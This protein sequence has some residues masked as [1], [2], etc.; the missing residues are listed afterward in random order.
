MIEEEH[1]KKIVAIALAALMMGTAF[2]GCGGGEPASQEAQKPTQTT[3][4]EPSEEKKEEKSTTYGTAEEGK[5]VLGLDDS[6][7]PMGFRDENNEIVGFDIDIAQ[8]VCDNLGLELVLQ[9]INWDTKEME[10]ET[11]NIDVI[12]N[13]LTITPER[14][15]S[16][17]LSKPYLNNNQ[18][19]CV[20]ADSEIS[21]KAE[22]AGKTVAV[23][24][25]SSADDALMKD[26]ISSEIAEKL[27]YDN[28][29]SALLDCK[30]GGCD[31][32]ILDEVVANYYAAKEPESYKVLE[33][34]L[35]KEEYAI[36]FKK[37][38]TKLH[39]AVMAEYDKLAEDGTLSKISQ[40]W[41]GKD[42]IVK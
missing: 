13:G 40:Q 3:P 26:A 2:S 5:F 15:E 4:E 41:F 31:A 11:G 10:L 42:I 37:G 39:D 25:G 19:I 6:L 33:E 20:K 30:I 17:L 36:A 27:E 28:N 7:P 23:Q 24:A 1:M 14:Q 32:V 34:S 9:P 21:S 22:L 16:M 8:A 12:W 38:N 29:V 35:Q 18:V